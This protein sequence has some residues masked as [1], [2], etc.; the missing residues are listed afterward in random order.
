[1]MKKIPAILVG[2]ALTIGLAAP[3]SAQKTYS[4]GTNKQGSLAYSTGTAVAKLLSDK[5]DIQTRVQPGAGSSTVVPQMNAG[6]ID[7]GVNNAAE[8]RFA[9]F[10]TYTFDGRPNPNL[11]LVAKVYPL[12]MAI[13]VPGDSEI[14]TIAQAKGKRMG[15]KFTSQT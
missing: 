8:S 7:F 12:Y 9:H 1:M 6:K 15:F 11:M 4:V 5:S 2:A 3:A 14:K 13:S 10:G